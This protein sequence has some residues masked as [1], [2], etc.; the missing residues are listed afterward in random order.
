MRNLS[1]IVCRISSCRLMRLVS[2]ESK[3]VVAIHFDTHPYWIDLLLLLIVEIDL[4]FELVFGISFE[5]EISLRS[6]AEYRHAAWWDSWSSRN[7]SWQFI[8][9]L[10]L[11]LTLEVLSG[12]IINDTR[13]IIH[14]RD[15][16]PDHMTS[17]WVSL[18]SICSLLDCHFDPF[19]SSRRSFRSKH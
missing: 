11:T 15:S 19:L 8:S 5:W 13:N 16:N 1:S 4:S 17:E 14:N 9:I 18:F 2:I 12:T 3:R 6:Y 7:A 10:T